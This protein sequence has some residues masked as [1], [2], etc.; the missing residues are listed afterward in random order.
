MFKIIGIIGGAIYGGF[1]TAVLGYFIGSLLDNIF[2]SKVSIRRQNYSRKDFSNTLL[3]L[4][5]AVVKADGRFA[6]SELYYIK[7]Y[8]VRTMGSARATEAMLRLQDIYDNDFNIPSVCAELRQDASIHERLLILQFLFGLANADGEM[9]TVEIAEIERIS[10]WC[11]ISHNDFESIKSMYTNYYY[12]QSNNSF[13]TRSS[14]NLDNDYKILE[15]SPDATDEEVKKA[16]RSL[17]KKY[18]PDRV[19]HLG[20][21]MRKAAEE[22]FA[23]LSQAYDNI[24]KARGIK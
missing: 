1:W 8:F 10:Q 15:I 24:K 14:Y 17:A 9:H 13:G 21:D 2:F 22:K 18:H 4:A 23:K 19:N 11:G 3:I 16:Y 7:D 12:Q 6:K 20:E 5:A